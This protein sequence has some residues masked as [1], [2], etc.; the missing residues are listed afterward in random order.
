MKE[1]MTDDN[2]MSLTGAYVLNALDEDE[3][4]AFEAKLAT[5]E[6][7]RSEV[8]ELSDTASLLGLSVQPVAPSDALKSSLM[9]RIASTPQL[10]AEEVN[11]E[12]EVAPEP[13]PVASLTK[14]EMKAQRR[15]FQRPL[16]ASLSVAAAGMVVLAG[17][18][19][20]LIS[21]AETTQVQA[22]GLAAISEASDA[23]KTVADF[24]DTGTA[25]VMWSEQE[26][27]SAVFVHDVPAL[28]PDQSYELWYINDSGEARS[29]GLLSSDSVD[30]GWH[31]LEGQMS[32]SERV[33]IT[34]EPKG[35]SEQPTTD[36]VMLANLV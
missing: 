13:T 31:V 28:N 12:A 32:D 19:G 4:K 17:V 24:G 16:V 15:W 6:E 14:A 25:T 30:R 3:R 21:G 36:P 18:S 33:G 20:G 11:V 23:Q 27:A 5:S 22:D 1:N 34:V 2:F 35:G 26:N 9:A 8:T 10:A 29:A 7:A